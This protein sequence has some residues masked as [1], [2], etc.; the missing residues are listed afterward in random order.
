[1]SSNIILIDTPFP[2]LI[3]GQIRSRL[4]TFSALATA[5]ATPHAGAS[6]N[7]Y[8]STFGCNAA[9]RREILRAPA[10]DPVDISIG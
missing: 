1:M 6:A 8:P 2:N 9:R 7:W 4:L 10:R 5:N 3:R